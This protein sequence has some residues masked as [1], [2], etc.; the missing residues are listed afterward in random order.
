L[1]IEDKY[2]SSIKNSIKEGIQG[3]RFVFRRKNIEERKKGKKE[4]KREKRKERK[5]IN[6]E[7]KEGK[8]RKKIKKD[9]IRGFNYTW[10]IGN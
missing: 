8:E 9:S 6:K 3:K 7:R 10:M 5:N 1:S 2:T 4:G